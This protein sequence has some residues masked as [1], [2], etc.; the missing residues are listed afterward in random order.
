MD[1]FNKIVKGIKDVKIQ[2]A[3]NIAKA[4]VKAYSLKPTDNSIKK[5]ISIRPT[6][7]ALKNSLVFA[8]KHGVRRT[9]SHFKESEKKILKHSKK[10]V[11]PV[12]FT[13]CHSSLVVKTLIQAKKQGKKFIVY[14]TETRP[15]LQ[16][17]KT[18]K[19]LSKAGIKVTQ[20]VDAVAGMTLRKKS[21]FK[22]SNVVLLGAD[23]ILKDGSVIN[24][25][26]SGMF[27]EIAH[28]N[29]V[30][31]YIITDSWKFTPKNIKIEERGFKEIWKKAP[32][33]VKI[34]NPAF[35]KIYPKHITKIVSELGILKPKKFVK[36][37][38]KTYPWIR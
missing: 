24:K 25:M 21:L 16:G 29:K 14:N 9:L 13:H 31:V 32:K 20:I 26:G 5:L 2:G 23:A 18:T 8:K 10:I 12:N 38:R 37:V 1:G 6:E 22:K 4:G 11:K 27:A 7:P 35:G 30:Q 15:L 33:N 36:K 3:T 34:K 19:E 17:R 28:H